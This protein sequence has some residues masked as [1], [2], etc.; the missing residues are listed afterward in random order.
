[1]IE[2]KFKAIG[3]PCPLC[4]AEMAKPVADHCHRTGAV[5]AWLCVKCNAG[6]GMFAD[7]PDAL[8][9]AADYVEHHAARVLM[10][11]DFVRDE[12][13]RACVRTE[14]RRARRR[15]ALLSANA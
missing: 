7:N 9:R 5:R 3:K 12:R 1:M 6:L 13:L 2:P 4:G 14:Q 8:R 10:P 11:E 15:L